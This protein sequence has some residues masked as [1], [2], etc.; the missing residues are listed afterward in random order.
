M[1]DAA[2]LEVNKIVCQFTKNDD[3]IPAVNGLQFKLKKGEIGCLLGASGCGK[4]TALRA[5]AGFQTL[6]GG[7][8]VL[9]GRTLSD[10]KQH[11]APER[12][13]IGMVFQDYA[14]F[15]HLNVRDNITFGLFKLKPATQEKIC[16]DLLKLVKLSGYEQRFPHELS[17]GQQ[18]RVALA[19]ALAPSPE[20]LLLDEPLSS[21]DTELRRTLALEL[22]SI[23]KQRNISTIMV[24][25]D[26]E[27]AF[28][29]ADRVG[30]VN[31]GRLEQWDMPYNLYHEPQ[32][33][34]VADFI[35][36]GVFLPGFIR[37]PNAIETELGLLQSHKHYSWLS[38]TE[39]EVLLRPDDIVLDD[40]SPYR[41]EV[42]DKIFAGT[43]TLYTLKL[44][45]GAYV[46][47]ALASHY[48]FNIGTQLGIK[49]QADHLIAFSACSDYQPKIN[50][51]RI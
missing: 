10:R 14:L 30:V 26:Q 16:T 45:S 22:R 5:I 43:S 41:A 31:Q 6:S 7:S 42:N 19:R 40:D 48:N 13:N 27:E 24:T 44:P 35:G 2:V 51:G 32:T 21:L 28:A 8:I 49:V 38:N 36:Q 34:F 20:L 1:T 12:R 18:Q 17:G 50:Q 15:P 11:V 29:F 33:R 39:V 4:T 47:A 46:E 25:H 23:L 37:E 9:N 3:E